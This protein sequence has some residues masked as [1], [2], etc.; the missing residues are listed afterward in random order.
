MRT[1]LVAFKAVDA[2]SAL[3]RSE[4]TRRDIFCRV[5]KYPT[6]LILFRYNIMRV[7][8]APRRIAQFYMNFIHLEFPKYI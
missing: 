1:R 5:Y 8:A 2:A 7:Y 6:V 4:W 3:K